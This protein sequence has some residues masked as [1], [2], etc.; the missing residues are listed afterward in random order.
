M[1]PRQIALALALTSSTLIACDSKPKA[2]EPP[3]TNAA[4][5]TAE[6]TAPQEADDPVEQVTWEQIRAAMKDTNLDALQRVERLDAFIQTNPGH[7][8]LKRAAALRKKY[9][10]QAD[11]IRAQ[12]ARDTASIEHADERAAAAKKIVDGGVVDLLGPLA[13]QSHTHTYS[14]RKK[15]TPKDYTPVSIALPTYETRSYD[16]PRYLGMGTLRL[17]ASELVSA[18]LPD[19]EVDEGCAYEE[20][21]RLRINALLSARLGGALLP[22]PAKVDPER[23][24]ALLTTLSKVDPKTPI[25]GTNAQALY[26]ANRHSI[27][28]YMRVRAV[29]SK[30]GDAK[31]RKAY[32]AALSSDPDDMLTFYQDFTRTHDVTAATGLEP[33]LADAPYVPVGFWMRRL[34]DGTA[35]AIFSSGLALL[36]TFDPAERDLVSKLMK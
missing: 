29:L 14:D 8:Q 28:H 34:A 25:L 5:A 13:Y 26:E 7:P 20:C 33:I 22:E 2:P 17:S 18:R 1:N 24:G 32:A 23:L 30:L 21:Q 6:T 35:D 15:P 3:Q 16:K 27:A 31:V 10:R 36:A 9:D 11:R 12:L 4:R 19:I